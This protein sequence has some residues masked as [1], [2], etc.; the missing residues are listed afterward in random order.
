MSQQNPVTDGGDE[1]PGPS[2]TAGRAH[3]RWQRLKPWQRIALPAGV[4]ALVTAVAAATVLNSAGEEE[5]STDT[6]AVTRE[7][8][9]FRE[10]VEGLAEAPGLHYQDT[11]SLG[12]TENDIT[13]T[14]GGSQF[15]STSSGGSSS[16]RDLLRIDG[17]TFMRWQVDPAPRKH[18]ASGEKVP[19]SEWAVGMDDGS[20]LVKE[21]LARTIAP[22][23]LAAVLDK[24]LSD[25][26]KAPPPAA[27]EPKASAAPGQPPV[28]VNGTPAL[29][30]NTS[31]G[32]LLV[33]KSAPHKVLRLEA[34][35]IHDGLAD[36]KEQLENGETPTAL[37]KVTTGPLASGSGEGMDL[38]PILGDAA[39][40]MFDTL[41]ER[42]GQLENATDRGINFSLDGAGEMDC[43]P[44]GCTA[45]QNFTGEVSS[46]ARRERVTKGEV[47]A[48]M[49]ATFTID[50][51][52]AGRCTSPQ[53]T[54]P[55][56]GDSVSGTLKCSNPGA[57]PLYAAVAARVQAQ[58][59]ADADRC[60][61]RVRLTY[62]L[63]AV[64]L[65]DARALAKV[66]ARKLADRAKR[67]RD[68]A[69]CVS[70]HSFPTGTRV[71][72]ADGTTRAI[73]DIRVGDRVAASSPLGRDSVA[74]PVTDVLT[75]EDDK[76]FTRLATSVGTVTATD[77]HPFWLADERRWVDAGD[78]ESGALLRV[79]SGA[80]PPVS[81][82]D[83]FTQRRTTHDL[84]VAGL[85]SY[86]VGVGGG[87][88]SVL[89][90]N[91]DC[92]VA[93]AR[94]AAQM[95]ELA[96]ENAKLASSYQRVLVKEQVDA[97]RMKARAQAQKEGKSE[98]KIKKAEDEAGKAA[99]EYVFRDYTTA[100]VR[101]R[102][103]SPTTGGWEERTFVA[104]SGQ[105]KKLSK[106]QI[107]AVKA[108][109]HQPVLVNYNNVR[110]AEQKLI[111]Y[112]R[113]LGGQPIAG[114]ASRN[115]CLETC[116]TL[117]TGGG[118][119]VDGDVMPGK[120]SG[121]RTFWFPDAGALPEKE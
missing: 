91:N 98:D 49:S 58:A 45:T 103:K 71:L 17:K 52:A 100:V 110:H 14:A 62:P 19:P 65:I 84:T 61:C 46:I 86:Y 11:S 7:L 12:I 16:G 36:L 8:R 63:R 18:G 24:A 1:P 48:V 97:A 35:D 89:V 4:V 105:G 38:T 121:V 31:A 64:T 15:G 118:G 69:H 27:S 29:G 88:A 101:A 93:K 99:K 28:S 25:L 82:V 34:Y 51:K 5:N 50:G 41:V 2:G 87:A 47:T 60:G 120:G 40:K 26:E 78:I 68:A 66:E 95:M 85:H 116:R 113:K 67:E 54:F 42:A 10:A 115:V 114:G 102:I 74:R 43:S 55:V 37:P 57:G 56:R 109:G 53:R 39:D 96:K 6:A 44:S 72:L 13:V 104:L 107:L 117:I 92:N 81:K 75:T 94:T 76:D 3:G 23:R 80:T 59:Q 83:R 79:P 33:T 32:R 20:E 106:K 70:P 119:R 90:H 73:E 77:T 108:E 112:I 111:L 30:V 21:A 9:P 22:S